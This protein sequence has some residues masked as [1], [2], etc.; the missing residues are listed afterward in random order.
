MSSDALHDVEVDVEV[1]VDEEKEQKSADI[2]QDCIR[3]PVINLQTDNSTDV[4]GD[5]STV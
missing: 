2:A 4:D 3:N 5:A 1:T